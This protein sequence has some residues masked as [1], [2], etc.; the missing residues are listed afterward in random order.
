MTNRYLP[1]T[2]QDQA[3][4][5]AAIGAETIE[6]LFSD[7][8]EEIRFKGELPVSSKLDEYALTRHMS[9]LAGRNVN[10]DTHPSFLGAGIY[11]HHVPSVINHVISR[12]EF[13]T[14]YTPYQPE[15]SQGELQAIFEFQSYICELTGMA[16][17]NASMYDGATAFA[18]A[19]N[20][21]ASATRRK[22]LVVS[23]TVH[24]ESRQVLASY[25]HGLNLEIVEIGYKNGVTDMEALAAAI[26]E[27]TAAVM[28]QSPNFFGSVEDIQAA[29]DLIHPN[30]GLLI[31]SANP[32]SL[33]LLEAPGKL[34]ADI[35]VGDAQPLGIAGSYGGPTCGYFAVSQAHMRRIP[36]RIVGQTTD[37]YGR[38]GF[39]LTLQ[40]REQHI[41][42]EKATSNICSN[43]ALLALSASVYMSL[44]GKQGMLD[45]SELNLQ[46]S[47][48]AKQTLA[49]IEGVSTP[50][51]S[52]TFN[53]FVI[54]LPDHTSMED[55][56]SKLLAAGFIG[57]YDLGREY[58]ELSG[59]MLIA[60][61]ERRSKE[62]IDEFKA[63]LEG[64]L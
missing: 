46:K 49:S 4:M 34:G 37:R 57:G 55:V 15:I 64:L 6:D 52:P 32:I 17:A 11:D 20:L 5:L 33:G 21:A 35:V 61:T 13:Y 8:P 14:A 39:V 42:R 38:R 1:M 3:E 31:V 25:A 30:K 40:A 10:A 29:A 47:H 56:Q 63:V 44:L 59:H 45:V 22:K 26:S 18:E 62:E 27:D 41:R 54:K 2:E 12:S 58:P 23:S 60:V 28:I 36:G 50:F 16:V 24:P 51:T 19:G 9:R 53:E 7:I 48:Y 43:Q